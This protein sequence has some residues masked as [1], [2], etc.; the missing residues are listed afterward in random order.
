MTW[1]TVGAGQQ[2]QGCELVQGFLIWMHTQAFDA[3]PKVKTLII[4]DGHAALEVDFV[5]THT[6]E[7][8]GMPATDK[9]VQVRPIA[10]SMTCTATRPWPRAPTSLW[11]CIRDSSSDQDCRRPFHDI[12]DLG[13]GTHVL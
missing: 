8:L 11:S 12:P 13:S 10:W 7:F 2:L 5:G 6:G 4:R 9:S 1:T 3:H